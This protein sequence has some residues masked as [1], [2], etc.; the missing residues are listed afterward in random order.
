MAVANEGRVWWHALP[1]VHKARSVKFGGGGGGGREG[2]SLLFL[3]EGRELPP[4]FNGREGMTSFFE[5]PRLSSVCVCVCV[6]VCVR[7]LF[8]FVCLFVMA[9]FST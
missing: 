7:E 5:N 9:E 2:G 4:F 8:C 3:W 6:C 1:V